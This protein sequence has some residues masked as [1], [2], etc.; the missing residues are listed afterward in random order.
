MN[1][2]SLEAEKIL[3][4]IIEH[5]DGHGNCDTQYWEKRFDKLSMSEDVLLRSSFK[6]LSDAG[7]ICTKW[8]DN[9]PYTLFILA[10]GKSYFDE[11]ETQLPNRITNTYTNVFYGSQNEVQIQ[12]GTN[13]SIQDLTESNVND[14]VLCELINLIK[15]Y[16]IILDQEFGSK[17]A[18]DLRAHNR[19]L[20][21]AIKHNESSPNKRKIISAIKDIAT[22][23]IGGVISG[24]IISLITKI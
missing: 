9:Y 21:E 2:V 12:Q 10:K 11:C 13:H 19:E 15:R 22:N 6:E 16:D 17:Q 3:H 7:L 23:A 5:C 1:K 8:A 4:E 24:A 14:D 18:S 20:E